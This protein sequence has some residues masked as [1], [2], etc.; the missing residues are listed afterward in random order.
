MRLARPV[1]NGRGVL[2]YDINT[3]LTRQGLEGIRNF[4]L[5]GV[6]VLEPAEPAPVLTE[7]DI[8]FEKFQ[9]VSV[10]K[11]KEELIAMADHKGIKNIQRMAEDIIKRYGHENRKINFLKSMRRPFDYT[12]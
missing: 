1:Y 6:Y 10:L 4:G 5:M 7:D 3:K 12:Y 11:L 2:L 9:A 8:E